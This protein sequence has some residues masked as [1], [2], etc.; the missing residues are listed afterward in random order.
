MKKVTVASEFIDD[1][2]EKVLTHDSHPPL[3]LSPCI[4]VCMTCL[5]VC[6]SLPPPYSRLVSSSFW[7][8]V[9]LTLFLAIFMDYF[10]K[11]SPLLEGK[12]RRGQFVYLVVVIANGGGGVDGSFS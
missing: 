2:E 6:L 11:P 3:M 8:K 5:S 10:F 12:G 1:E 7:Q 4:Y 9:T